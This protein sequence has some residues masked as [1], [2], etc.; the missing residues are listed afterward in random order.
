SGEDQ[1]L[2]MNLPEAR[3]RRPDSDLFW[4][5]SG[6]QFTN[7][8]VAAAYRRP[9]AVFPSLS[10]RRCG[11]IQLSQQRIRCIN[12]C[13][14][15]FSSTDPT[16][17][18]SPCSRIVCNRRTKLFALKINALQSGFRAG[19]NV[20]PVPLPPTETSRKKKPE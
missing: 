20:F 13:H 10:Q 4:K 14:S 6:Q 3:N 19:G 18:Y 5:P 12:H 11:G 2:L 9:I 7:H 15:A 17:R 8:E 1:H 16:G